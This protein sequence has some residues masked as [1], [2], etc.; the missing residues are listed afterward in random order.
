MILLDK[1]D[2]QAIERF[3][4]VE[5]IEETRIKS[6]E[7]PA[8]SSINDVD[9]GRKKDWMNL[10]NQ[11][12]ISSAILYCMIFKS[13]STFC[14]TFSDIKYVILHAFPIYLVYALQFSTVTGAVS[15]C[16]ENSNT[17]ENFC[18]ISY[19][20]SFSVLLIFFAEVCWK[21][22][23]IIISTDIV[24]F[25]RQYAFIKENGFNKRDIKMSFTKRAIVFVF[26]IVTD[27]FILMTLCLC[28]T[29][30][31]LSSETIIELIFNTVL[32]LFVLNI[33]SFILKSFQS[34]K[35]S[36]CVKFFKFETSF[37]VS[38]LDDPALLA[39]CSLGYV[40]ENRNE[41]TWLSI[42]THLKF[43]S[44]SRILSAFMLS[45]ICVIISLCR[46]V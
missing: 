3:A 9:F 13:G 6:A 8:N 10:P 43:W 34:A 37:E 24:L 40:D 16:L 14:S 29:L 25:S 38:S 22:N 44:V 31:L 17:L 7:I 30:Y 23:T 26:F 18:D 5:S 1:K 41:S 21:I 45:S 35:A 27:I 12:S 2:Y 39:N 28:G 46:C 19:N 15:F 36:A 11:S 4:S 32:M 42:L 33:D 20:A